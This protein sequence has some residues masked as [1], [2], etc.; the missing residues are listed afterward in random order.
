M[1]VISKQRVRVVILFIRSVEGAG[2]ANDVDRD[3][4]ERGDEG[5][6]VNEGRVFHVSS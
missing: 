2:R 1:C 3:L 6:S 4:N 5:M